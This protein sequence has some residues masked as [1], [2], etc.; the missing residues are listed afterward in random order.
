MSLS[1]RRIGLV[2]AR[3]YKNSIT[4]RGFLIGLLI[5]PVM[6]VLFFVL[7]P[8]ILNSR[9][10]QVTGEVALIDATGK[11]TPQLQHA[12]VPTEIAARRAREATTPPPKNNA[13]AP[14]AAAGPPIAALTVA[15]QPPDTD[16]QVFKTWLI[17]SRDARPQHLAIVVVQPDAIARHT[18]ASAFGSYD[19]YTSARLDNATEATLRDSVRA[20]LVSARLS[21]D[22]LDA[23]ALDKVQQVFQPDSVVVAA[24]GEHSGS[25]GI[26]QFLPLASGILIFIG[27]VMGGTVMMTSTVEEKSN[28]VIEVLLAAVSPLELMYGKLLG[29]LGL[30]LTMTAVYLFMGVYLLAQFSLSG[31]LDPLLIVYVL[32]FYLF[33]F[34][35][36]GSLML[37]I[38]SVVNQMA[39]AQAFQGPMMI[40][41]VGG[42]VLTPIIGAAPNSSFSV[43]MSFLPFINTYAMMA[44]VASSAPPPAWQVAATMLVSCVTVAG[45][46]WFAAKI[47]KI[48]LLMHGKPPSLATLI[49]WARMA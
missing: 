21:A 4:S 31:L 38:G 30:G 18:G 10:P 37:T 19:L 45:V 13:V 48:G 49:K 40:L 24:Q 35:V 20:A 17:Q 36:F 39:D 42:Y 27:V 8:R 14:A 16:V 3:D 46:V 33:T 2:A 41:L 9:T 23:T 43:T 26:A 32:V 44:R 28:R 5:M 25:R 15:P 12:L 6:M 7:V 11:V 22:G 47:F 29:H 34:L 1:L